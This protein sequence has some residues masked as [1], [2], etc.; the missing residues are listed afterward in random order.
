M[1][2]RQRTTRLRLRGRP[3]LRQV[4]SP[5]PAAQQASSP[6]VTPKIQQLLQVC[7]GKTKHWRSVSSASKK[8]Y[9]YCL[10]VC[11]SVCV[12]GDTNARAVSGD[13][14]CRGVGCISVRRDR[15]PPRAQ[16]HCLH[17]HKH[18]GHCSETKNKRGG[19]GCSSRQR[20]DEACGR[21]PRGS[22]SSAG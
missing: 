4:R 10:Y 9:L 13:D 8:R 22:K 1:A 18:A 15:H 2:R 17:A 14:R 16:A 5:S 7:R 20:K 11:P 19:R 21:G 12:R 6:G 3:N